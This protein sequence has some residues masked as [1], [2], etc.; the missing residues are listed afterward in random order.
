MDAFIQ[1]ILRMYP[2]APLI[3]HATFRDSKLKHFFIPQN[4][5]I[6]I[7]AYGINHDE[8][9]FTNPEVFDPKRWLEEDGTSKDM[10]ETGYLHLEQ[11]TDPVLEKL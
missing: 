4:T 2:I 1:E 5:T 3:F 11:A 6:L 8:N 7:N 10:K 9:H